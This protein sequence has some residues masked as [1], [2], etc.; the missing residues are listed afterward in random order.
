LGVTNILLQ[1]VQS[2][3]ISGINLPTVNK[4]PCFVQNT[5]FLLNGGFDPR[6][7]QPYEAVRMSFI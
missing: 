6:P 7:F 4:L 2:T 1:N 5:S 3:A